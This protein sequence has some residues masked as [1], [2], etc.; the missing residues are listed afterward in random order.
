MALGSGSGVPSS[1]EVVERGPLVEA[2]P[3]MEVGPLAVEAA[4]STRGEDTVLA[5]FISV[6]SCSEKFN[7]V[8]MQDLVVLCS[9]RLSLCADFCLTW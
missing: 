5:G 1:C 4:V 2:G 3:P 8:K 9:C 7:I 6:S